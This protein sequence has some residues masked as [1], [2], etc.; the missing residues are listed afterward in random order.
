MKGFPHLSVKELNKLSFIIISSKTNKKIQ[1]TIPHWLV[2]I[3][4][5]LIVTLIVS[6]ANF[7]YRL[8]I[9][10]HQLSLVNEQLY[11]LAEENNLQSDEISY[12]RNKS[13]TIEEKLAGLNDLQNKVLNMV[14]LEVKSE[15]SK[16]IASFLVSRSDQRVS[17]IEDDDIDVEL[18]M[19]L[20]DEL[21]GKQMETMEQLI[22]DVEKQLKYIES[23]PNLM[24]S[25]GRITSPFGY[26]ISPINRKK[27]FHSGIDI[28]NKTNTD[29]IAAGGGIV[30]FANYNGGYGRMII[31]SHG[32]GYTSVYA[33]NSKL[34]VKVGDK[35]S[36]GD[37]IAK[38]GSTGRSTGPHLHFEIRVHGKAV[39]PKTI[40]AN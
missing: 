37:S 1:F 30:T 33:H 12:L 23:Q 38:M 28:A 2:L 32:Y 24:P 27:E 22:V 6:A 20:L 26:R 40:L 17:V 4:S 31:I 18:E 5:A 35:V 7:S 8:I 19:E 13:S 10:N 34:L 25:T 11:Q 36:K 3:S 9:A 29:V 21:I 39:D 15:E 16:S 14:G